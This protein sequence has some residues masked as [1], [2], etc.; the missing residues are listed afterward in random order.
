MEWS[1]ARRDETVTT[2]HIKRITVN[3]SGVIPEIISKFL[4]AVFLTN[5]FGRS[6]ISKV[7]DC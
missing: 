5:D 1:T 7:T 3:S 6:S 4:I 2:F